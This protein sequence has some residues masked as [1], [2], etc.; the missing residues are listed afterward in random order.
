M[1]AGPLKGPVFL[2]CFSNYEYKIYIELYNIDTIMLV[3]EY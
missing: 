2:Y 3:K 1:Y